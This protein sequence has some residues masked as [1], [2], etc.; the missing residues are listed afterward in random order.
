MHESTSVV[1]TSV[2]TVATRGHD[3]PVTAYGAGLADRIDWLL[4][5]L[6][7][8]ARE[9]A[10]R[11][12]LHESHVWVM[13][14]RLRSRPESAPSTETVDAIARAAEVS[15]EWLATG[16]GAPRAKHAITEPRLSELADWPA[17]LAHAS[18]AH[19]ELPP[20]AFTQAGRMVLAEPGQ[21]LDVDF[22]VDLARAWY[23][24]AAREELRRADN[25]DADARIDTMRRGRQRQRK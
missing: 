15:F 7:V 11:A 4:E 24:R 18:K 16:R 5:D 2:A 23:R 14:S 19:P 22:V 3:A 20:V 12:G 25:A 1:N 17:V 6:D 8:S 13:V 10:R 9:L 21:A